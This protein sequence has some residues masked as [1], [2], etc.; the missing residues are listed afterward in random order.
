MEPES[1]SAISHTEF[2]EMGFK[3]TGR[4]PSQRRMGTL[5]SHGEEGPA[6]NMQGAD[7]GRRGSFDPHV[8]SGNYNQWSTY[9]QGFG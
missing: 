3:S 1:D 9:N 4:L 2:S 8:R 6:R 7:D 5:Y